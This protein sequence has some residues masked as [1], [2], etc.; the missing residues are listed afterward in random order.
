MPVAASSTPVALR[1]DLPA[2][3]RS[4]F[5]QGMGGGAEPAS[6]PFGNVGGR[7]RAGALPASGGTAIGRSL[8]PL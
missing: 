4:M 2:F 8:P 7:L 5:A 6:I 1:G 3:G